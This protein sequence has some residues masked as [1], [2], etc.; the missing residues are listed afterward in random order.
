MLK[1][2]IRILLTEPSCLIREGFQKITKEYSGKIKIS[3]VESYDVFKSYIKSF[4]FDI[5]IINPSLINNNWKEL[6]TLKKKY[7]KTKWI[8]LI[9]AYFDNNILNIF[10]SLI[11]INDQKY[12]I[13]DNIKNLGNQKVETKDK[14][15]HYELSEREIDVL[16][17]LSQGSS[18]KQIANKL[19]ISIHTVISHRK[20]IVSKTGIKSVSGLTIYAVINKIIDLK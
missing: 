4:E 7:Y 1:D 17:L 16:K 12:T 8:G 6:V 13:L 20:N 10:D 9:Y 15:N 11:T 14:K 3:F 19:N 5:I 2:E 18:N